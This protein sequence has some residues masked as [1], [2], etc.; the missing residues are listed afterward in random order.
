MSNGNNKFIVIDRSAAAELVSERQYQ[1]VEFPAGR[2]LVESLGGNVLALQGARAF[3]VICIEGGLF[4]LSKKDENYDVLVID[5][6]EAPVFDKRSDSDVLYLFQKIVRF[7]IKRWERMSFTMSERTLP[8]STKGLL[9]P[10]PFSSQT[11]F[12]ITFELA[13]DQRRREKRAKGE[14]LLLY[15]CG[16][17]EGRGGAEEASTTIFRKAIDALQKA[18]RL[19]TAKVEA[20]IE[21]NGAS[22]VLAVTRLKP[23]SDHLNLGEATL[24][25]W[26]PFLSDAQREFIRSPISGPHRIEGPAGTG[27]TISLVLKCISELREAKNEGRPFKALFVAHSEATRRNIERLFQPEVELGEISLDG[28]MS[29]QA[30]QVCT[31]HTFCAQILNTEISETE[32][33]DRDAFESKQ[34]QLIYTLEALQETVKNELPTYRSLMSEG[35]VRFLENEDLWVSAEMLQHEI[36]V[37]IKGRADEDES[38][39]RKLPRLRYGL[40]VENDDDRVFVFL[41][42]RN[43]RKRLESAGLF[44]TDDVI[45]STLGQLNTPIW[46]RRRGREGFDAIFID[47]TH[48]FNLNELSVFH[49]LTRRE[50]LFPIAYSADVSQSLGD[51][52]WTEEGFDAAMGIDS[53]DSEKDQATFFR[54]IF[55][56]S[57]DIVNLAFSVT[58]SGATLFT[59]FQDPI[60]AS[61]SAFTHDEERKCARPIYWMCSTDDQMFKKAFGRVDEIVAEMGCTKADIVLIAFGDIVFQE[62]EKLARL[63]NKPVEII[64]HRGDFEVVQRARQSGRF[65]LTTPDYVGGLEFSAALLVGVDKDRV[66]PR[67]SESSPDSQNF[68][69]YASHQRLYVAI[70]RA[71]FR[72]EILGLETRGASTLLANAITN[73]LV[74][75]S[76]VR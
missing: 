59:N 74:D 2:E 21:S 61:N 66:P 48:L 69:S 38:K 54:S 46:R 43:Y 14:E 11:P 40:P 25:D 70:T 58:S 72:V 27:K 5:L 8:N 39:Y 60:A 7:A 31:L 18:Q 65:I 36:S 13:P 34:A 24:D 33:L 10:Y 44:D 1:S 9:F 56:C 62:F 45:L 4:F 37:K 19:A 75:I 3:S 76:V 53:S 51:R 22:S 6:S 29:S 15:K 71:R 26:F 41:A 68:L 49:R 28:V 17:E 16:T 35:F 52:G 30:V 32:F 42:F 57:P 73:K 50:D 47:E 23:K 63:M 55:R 12:R 20:Q 64:K 67:P